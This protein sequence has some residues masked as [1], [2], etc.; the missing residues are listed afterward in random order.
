[1]RWVAD[2]GRA[3]RIR[4]MKPGRSIAIPGASLRTF[5]V[6]SGPRVLV[7]EADRALRRAMMTRLSRA[8]YEPDGV[9]DG[10]D[11]VAFFRGGGSADVV[12]VDADS[13]GGK[14]PG[15]GSA[16]LGRVFARIARAAPTIVC[17]AR[18]RVRYVARRRG[19]KATALRGAA[20]LARF[21]R[22]VATQL[23]PA[24]MSTVATPLPCVAH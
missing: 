21:P 10:L 7:V 14:R 20:V 23:K 16:W 22:L 2:T 6:V 12:V 11:A 1:M 18:A 17:S 5:V 9:D 8:G 3:V 24:A 13:A 4:E 19:A 15:G